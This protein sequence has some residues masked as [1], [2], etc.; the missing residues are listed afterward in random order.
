MHNNYIQKEVKVI[1]AVVKQLK[2]LQERK[3]FFSGLS[4]QLLH[5]CEDHFHFYSSSTVQKYDLYH[6]HHITIFVAIMRI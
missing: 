6:I 5:N 3:V 1:F 4:L 2:Q